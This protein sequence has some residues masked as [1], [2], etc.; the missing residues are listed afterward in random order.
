MSEFN[1]YEKIISASYD[2]IMVTDRNGVIIWPT[3]HG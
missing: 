2:A 3:G 1:I